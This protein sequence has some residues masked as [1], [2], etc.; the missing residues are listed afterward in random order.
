MK[1]VLFLLSIITSL[2]VMGQEPMSNEAKTIADF[3]YTTNRIKL[4]NPAEASEI[5]E[6]KFIGF[7]K[8]DLKKWEKTKVSVVNYVV[9]DTY[10]SKKKKKKKTKKKNWVKSNMKFDFIE[11]TFVFLG[12]KG[13][14]VSESAIYSSDKISKFVPITITDNIVQKYISSKTNTFYYVVKLLSNKEFISYGFVSKEEYEKSSELKAK[15]FA[16]SS[17]KIKDLEFDKFK[18]ELSQEVKAK[19]T[20]L[21]PDEKIYMY[22]VSYIKKRF[23]SDQPPVVIYTKAVSNI[24]PDKIV[25]ENFNSAKGLTLNGFKFFKDFDVFRGIFDRVINSGYTYFMK[26]KNIG[27]WGEWQE[28]K[29]TW[30]VLI[31]EEKNA[32]EKNWRNAKKFDKSYF[33]K[34]IT[35]KATIEKSPLQLGVEYNSFEQSKNLF[36]FNLH[37]GRGMGKEM[38]ISIKSEGEKVYFKLGSY[39]KE[40]SISDMDNLSKKLDTRIDELNFPFV[41]TLKGLLGWHNSMPEIFMNKKTIIEYRGTVYAE[42]ISG[43]AKYIK[44]HP[45]RRK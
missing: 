7:E 35:N 9:V 42:G 37:F 3:Y 2:N 20:K 32:I 43:Y 25:K 41:Y 8:T 40:G 29:D 23:Y 28:G 27:D 34:K 4:L 17:Q 24:H 12:H 39:S 19:I 38:K 16:K 30:D 22:D 31:N 15:Q 6:L 33:V 1:K 11:N 13:E 36:I 44:T 5:E 10:V 14:R 45:K 18:K 21:F 26:G